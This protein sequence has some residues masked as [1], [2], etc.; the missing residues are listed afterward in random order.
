MQ[1]A[2]GYAWERSDEAA[3]RS[4]NLLVEGQSDSTTRGEGRPRTGYTIFI[5][6]SSFLF[7]AGHKH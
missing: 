5:K 4:N 3:K 6:Q 7:P 2:A 1:Q